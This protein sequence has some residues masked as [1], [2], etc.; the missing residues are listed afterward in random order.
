MVMQELPAEILQRILCHFR[1]SWDD[2][3]E[4]CEENER[5]RFTLLSCMLTSKWLYRAALPILYHTVELSS[6]LFVRCCIRNPELPKLVRQM[7]VLPL[8]YAGLDVTD[9]LSPANTSSPRG[10][11]GYFTMEALKTIV[12]ESCQCSDW[13]FG[14]MILGILPRLECLMLEDYVGIEDYVPAEFVARCIGFGQN[15]KD[16]SICPL[17]KLRKV[18]IATD[19]DLP[20]AHIE[21][22]LEHLGALLELPSI[23]ALEGLRLTGPPFSNFDGFS[24]LKRL[25]LAST[26]LTPK[27][28]IQVL[29]RCPELQDLECEWPFDDEDD[30][31]EEPEIINWSKMGEVLSQHGTSLRCIKF[32]AHGYSDYTRQRN[33]ANLSLLTKLCTLKLPAEVVADSISGTNAILG[34]RFP[35][36]PMSELLP[37]SLTHLLVTSFWDD[38]ANE[39]HLNCQMS[40]I[41]SLPKFLSLRSIT[42]NRRGNSLGFSTNMEKDGWRIGNT[43]DGQMLTRG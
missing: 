28:L 9:S 34:S 21:V 14:S 42:V 37:S 6:L 1:V 8:D 15:S 5:R 40:M 16:S 30:S 32:E 19:P 25:V 27:K 18:T 12:P 31:E 4:L 23:A 26:N 36:T 3:N 33:V 22:N 29:S 39:A 7:R 38:P 2:D 10:P 20:S 24:T 35:M 41:M 43:E 11:A 13:P 17:K